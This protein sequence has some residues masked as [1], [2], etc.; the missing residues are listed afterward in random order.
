MLSWTVLTYIP[1]DLV[2]YS[3]K[4]IMADCLLSPVLHNLLWTTKRMLTWPKESWRVQFKKSKEKINHIVVYTKLN[5][6]IKFSLKFIFDVK[7]SAA[8]CWW[9]R[10][11]GFCFSLSS[12]NHLSLAVGVFLEGP[13][14]TA[15]LPRN[16]CSAASWW[17]FSQQQYML[18]ILARASMLECKPCPRGLIRIPRLL[19]LLEPLYRIL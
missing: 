15:S 17:P 6:L 10:S 7:I 4:R 19:Q 14:Q 18:D 3:R 1:K 16:A 8:L 12:T 9:H 2:A 5:K 13:W 11:H